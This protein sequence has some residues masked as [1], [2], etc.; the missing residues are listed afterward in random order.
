MER[1]GS[2]CEN[3]IAYLQTLS[4]HRQTLKINDL[5]PSI[6]AGFVAPNSTLIGEVYVNQYA[7]V[8]YNTTIRAELN[9]VRIGSYSSIGDNCS[10]FTACAT[11]TGV[12]ASVTIGNHVI[13]ESNCTIYSSIIDDEVYIGSG[14]VIGEG[15]KIEKGAVIAPNSFVP[16]GRLITGYSLWAGNPVKLVK[17]LS[18]KDVYANYIQ[19][20]DTWNLTQQHL[21]SLKEEPLSNNEDKKNKKDR[22]EINPNSLV[23]SYLAENYFNYKS[24]YNI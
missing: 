20:F 9:P 12:P 16:P 1:A 21:N 14:T 11:P 7:S 19:T 3:D 15:C 4:R 13:I 23:G 18:E 5:Q 22:L 2:K 24:K 6:E 17:E 8:W 10:I